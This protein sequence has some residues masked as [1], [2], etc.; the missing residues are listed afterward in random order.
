MISDILFI[1]FILS[2][3]SSA[4]LQA[5]PLTR[6]LFIL[7]SPALTSVRRQLVPTAGRATEIPYAPI[8]NRPAQI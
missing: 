5:F 2:N 1:L 4:I 3:S 6:V 8:G 7:K